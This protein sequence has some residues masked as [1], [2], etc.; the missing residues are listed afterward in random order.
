MEKIELDH[1][2]TDERKRNAG[3]QALVNDF[4]VYDVYKAYATP[5][6]LYQQRR[7]EHQTV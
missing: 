5:Q 3:N 7:C 4:G 1:I 2:R 6:E